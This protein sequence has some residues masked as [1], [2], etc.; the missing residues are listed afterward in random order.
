MSQPPQPPPQQQ[1]QRHS[2]ASSRLAAFLGYATEDRSALPVSELDGLGLRSGSKDKRLPPSRSPSLVAWL[3]KKAALDED[4]EKEKEKELGG[5]KMYRT[6]SQDSAVKDRLFTNR[7][8][9]SKPGLNQLDTPPTSLPGSPKPNSQKVIQL[10]RC[11]VLRD[12]KIVKDETLWI[13]NGKFVDS[14]SLFFAGVKADV[15]IDFGD[16]AFPDKQ[17]PLIVPGFIDL[18]I[19]GYFGHDFAD[20]VTLEEGLTA[21]AKGLPQYGVTSFLPT[22][23][24]SLP[25]TYHDVLPKIADY[26]GAKPKQAE[27]LGAHVEGPFLAPSKKGAHNVDYIRAPTNGFQDILECYGPTIDTPT[28][29]AAKANGVIKILTLAPEREGALSAI[30]EI[31]S[32]WGDNL[33]ISMGHT[34]ASYQDAEKALEVGATM[35]THLFNAMHPFHHRDPGPMG[36]LGFNELPHGTK[37]PWYGLIADG[38]HASAASIRVAYNAFPDGAV[39]VTDAMAGAGLDGDEFMLGSMKVRRKGPMEVVIDGTDTLAGSVATMPF[40]ISNLVKFAGCSLA[41]AVNAATIAP[42]KCIGVY[43]KKGS[44]SEG[45]DAD[46][47]VLDG[48]EEGD[49]SVF[50]VARVYIAGEEVFKA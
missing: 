3:E 48:F 13:Q 45:A 1:Q 19:N 8:F 27:I 23:V 36:V 11:D 2:T 12:G 33:V 40:C 34:E 41:E 7:I 17:R 29:E 15:V 10:I 5:Q 32:R 26:R 42:A 20:T 28:S 6:P 50:R 37:K 21:V 49:E 44:L 35:L 31:K 47:V 39:L 24:T 22:V 18:Q 30:Q 16:D 4:K 14:K 25:E 9:S 38:I 43:G 46:F